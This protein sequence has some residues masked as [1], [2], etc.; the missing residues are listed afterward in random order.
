MEIVFGTFSINAQVQTKED[1]EKLFQELAEDEK[2]VS[3]CLNSVREEQIKEFGKPLPKVS[4]HC[5][6]G[7]PIRDV[8]PYYPEA[9]RRSKIRGEV[10]VDTIV[11]EKGKVIFAKVTKGSGFLRKAD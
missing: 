3:A 1:R 8:K 7:C 11:D 2:A 4:G 6:E 10:I 5:W 9:A